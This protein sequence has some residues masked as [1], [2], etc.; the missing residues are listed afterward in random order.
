M[1]LFKQSEQVYI[2]LDDKKG[3]SLCYGNQ[4]VALSDL[5]NVDGA[6]ALHQK[7]QKICEE[8]KDKAGLSSC[9]GDQATILAGK[10]QFGEALGLLNQALEICE[11]LGDIPNKALILWNMGEVFRKQK[12]Y[13]Q[14][15]E[16]WE[17]AIELLQKCDMPTDE[18]QQQLDNLKQY[19]ASISQEPQSKT[20]QIKARAFGI[21]I[22]IV[23]GLVVY[24]Y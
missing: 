13:Q 18:K 10:E 22:F 5:D 6:M 23:V 2:E 19:V 24:F 1:A 9:Y 4:A 16:L 11:E 14:V 7:E 20:K 8:L 12:N 21:T 15:I 17:Q 3:L